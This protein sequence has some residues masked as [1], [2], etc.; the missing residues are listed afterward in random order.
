MIKVCDITAACL[1]AVEDISSKPETV[2]AVRQAQ[3]IV[4]AA[5]SA[6][7]G[8]GVYCRDGLAQLCRIIDDITQ[9]RGREGDLPLL[10]DLCALMAEVGD[11]ELSSRAGELVLASLEAYEAEWTAH[12]SGK[13]CPS[14]SCT[15]YYSIHIGAA[16]CDACGA[17]ARVCPENAIRGGEGL[18][19][20]VD[21]SRCTKCGECIAA[22]PKGII[23]R[24]GFI[25]PR[26]PAEP[27]PVG[28][29]KVGGL[30]KKSYFN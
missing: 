11:C 1:P 16:A 10:K 25:K 4:H 29:F 17:C 15:A 9:A 13:N 27:V 19:H 23:T 8:K 18:I 22:C 21:Q 24:A 20:V 5:R 26:E 2:C 7:C 12:L 30:R 3:Q 28:S 14:M 6:A